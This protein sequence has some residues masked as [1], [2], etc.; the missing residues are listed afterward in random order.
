LLEETEEIRN[1]LETTHEAY[2]LNRKVLMVQEI[3]SHL[4]ASG[5][6]S[7]D[8]GLPRLATEEGAE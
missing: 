6:D 2:L 1:I 5:I 3:R 4:K 7:L 8:D